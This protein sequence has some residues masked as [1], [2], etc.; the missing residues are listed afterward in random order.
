MKTI[1]DLLKLSLKPLELYLKV[2]S[3]RIT[4]A[5]IPRTYAS[6][7]VLFGYG[8]AMGSLRYAW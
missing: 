5:D 7:I 6:W 8:I 3:W 1:L 4:W 2:L